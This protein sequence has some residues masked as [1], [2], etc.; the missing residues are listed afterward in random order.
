MPSPLKRKLHVQSSQ[1]SSKKLKVAIPEYHTA[2]S[3]CDGAGEIIWPARKQ[4][5]DRA[6]DVIK[7]W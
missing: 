5:I 7:K 1:P 2:L 6:R 3:Q 4:Q